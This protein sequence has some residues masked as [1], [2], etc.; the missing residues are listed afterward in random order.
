MQR[1]FGMGLRTRAVALRQFSSSRVLCDKKP[2]LNSG[3]IGHVDHGKTTLTAAITRFLANKGQ[4][5]FKAYDAIDKTAEERE[6]G[7]TIAASH[8]EYE[9]EKRHF[10]HIDCPGHQN[11][12]K[13]MIVGAAQM[14]CGIL[15]VA[16]TSGAQEQTREHLLLAREVGIRD[17]VVYL[18]KLD[19]L[20]AEPELVEMAE[21]E[22][23]ALLEEYGYPSD[24]PVIKGSAR[25]ALEEDEPSELGAGSME[26]LCDALDN[27]MTM[28]D[29]KVDGDFLMPIE[30]VFSISGRGTVVTGKIEQ[31]RLK[32]G[33]EVETVGMTSHGINSIKTQCTGIEMFNK[34]MDEAEAGENIGALLR[35]VKRTDVMRGQVLAKPS[36]VKPYTRFV[37]KAYILKEDEGGRKHA[38]Y[39]KYMPQFFLRSANVT[40]ALT[41]EGTSVDGKDRPNMIMPGETCEFDVKLM[42]PVALNEGQRFAMREGKHTIASGVVVKLLD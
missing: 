12:I 36:T 37:A 11:Y 6:R 19:G 13:N 26:K 38:I 34:S 28:P 39:S 20:E 1:M 8:V 40:G 30:D 21:E 18:N 10:S 25:L 24:A 33:D 15:V 2:H 27:Y 9:T 23:R 22:V 35:G 3:T 5:K 14:D 32:V 7:I 17:I 16:A 42:Q 4:A 29:R 41:L 31:G